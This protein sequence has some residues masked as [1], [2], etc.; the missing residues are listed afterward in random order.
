MPPAQKGHVK[1]DPVSPPKKRKKSLQ[2]L[3]RALKDGKVR[4]GRG[5][6]SVLSYQEELFCQFYV[7]D[8]KHNGAQAAIKAGYARGTA[9]EQAYGLLKKQKIKDYCRDLWEPIEKAIK[10]R[11][12]RTKLT[13]NRVLEEDVAIMA[14]DIRNY[15]FVQNGRFYA[16]DSVLWSDE[17]AGAV[18]SVSQTLEGVKIQ[19]HDKHPSIGRLMKFLKMIDEDVPPAGSV[20]NNIVNFYLPS[21]RQLETPRPTVITLPPKDVNGKGQSQ[22]EEG[23]GGSVHTPAIPDSGPSR[24]GSEPESDPDDEL[25]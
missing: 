15:G 23:K 24:N 9:K 7:S 13:N 1:T 16:K 19:L 11:L 18:R 6:K 14:A 4:L 25:T 22:Q 12:K 5:N 8:P 21:K 2:R 17:A 3:N 20:T 10:E